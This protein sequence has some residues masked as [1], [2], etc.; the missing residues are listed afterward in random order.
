MFLRNRYL[1]VDLLRAAA[2]S[3]MTGMTVF[4]TFLSPDYNGEFF[5]RLLHYA[6]SL[7]A[8]AF[9]VISGFVFVVSSQGRL[10]ELRRFSGYSRHK[11]W[12]IALILLVA[13]SIHL[14]FFSF[15]TML[16]QASP[17]D[18]KNI[19]N[20]DVLQ[21]IA[22][23]LLILL[24]GR[25][26][27][28]SDRI[29]RFFTIT[30]SLVFTLPAPFL[31]NTDFSR[32][33]PLPL[34]CYFNEIHGSHFPLFPWA[35][36]IFAGATLAVYYL[37][38][39]ETFNEKDFIRKLSIFG[40]TSYLICFI[41]ISVVNR[42]AWFQLDPSPLFFLERFGVITLLL[43]ACWLYY[44]RTGA[45]AGFF[46]DAGRQSLV[47]YWLHLQI[48]TSRLWNGRS[49]SAIAGGTLGIAECLIATFILLAAMM[50]TAHVW[51]I[52]KQDNPGLAKKIFLTTICGSVILF[53]IR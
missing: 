37:K 33:I 13:Y 40:I 50:T 49:L 24:A 39:R 36:F 15:R 8:P 41:I 30:M 12:R 19:Y 27:T 10:D 51:G 38:A 53:L 31:W 23:G 22:A 44:R 7:A 20:V 4:N 2:L 43:C 45:E 14:P 28:K 3:A 6:I 17:S 32:F 25:R 11:L 21:C 9:M 48:I 26:L 18:I 16:T 34:A 1:F 5:F 42:Y 47:V 46:V 35:G 29:F 52:I